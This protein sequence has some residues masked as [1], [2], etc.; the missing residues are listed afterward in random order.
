MK[1]V[2]LHVHSNASDGTMSPSQVVAYAA[3]KNL[4]AMALTDHD[5]VE[6]VQEALT[7]AASLPVEVIPGMELSALYHEKEIHILGLFADYKNPQLL[8]QLENLRA[9]RSRRNS[10][11]L[12]RMAAD[13]ICITVEELQASNPDTVITRAHFARVLVERGIVSNMAQAFKKYLQTGGKYCPKKETFSPELALK[14]LKE[15][16]AF[17]ALAHPLQYKFGTEE[18]NGL[19]AHLK[20]LGLAGLEVYHSSNNQYESMKL[21]EMALKYQLLP[22]GGSDF[23]GKNKPDIDL[24]T[25]RGGLH[26]SSL[27]LEDIRNKH[28]KMYS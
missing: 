18:L 1:Y 17:P 9:V 16:R 4:S 27:L 19:V 25:G 23:H 3:S 5:T 21:K 6:G 7:A 20:E 22:T 11:I 15:C 10:V 24:G 8:K 14:L 28:S 12:E 26:V 13:G 2:D